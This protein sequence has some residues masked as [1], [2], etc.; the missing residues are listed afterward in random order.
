MRTTLILAIIAAASLAT[1]SPAFAWGTAAHRYIM[2]RAI[3]ML[4]ATLKPLFEPHRDELI[5]RVIDSD[6]WRTVGWEEDSNHFLD[7]GVREYGDYPFAALPREYD[8]ALETFGMATLRKNGTLPWREAEEFGNLRRAFERLGRGNGFAIGDVVLFTAVA[9]HYIQDAH[10][11]LHA[12]NN[13][14]GNLTGQEG[15]HARFETEL[16]ERFAARLSITP[17]PVSPIAN[18]RDFAFD[19]LLASYKLVEPLLAADRRAVAGKEEYDD[20]YFAKF[21]EQTRPILEQRIGASIAATAGLII[22]AWE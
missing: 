18:P 21:F 12:T 22:G 10:Q 17:P 14:D 3:E 13:H 19:V 4:P 11:P 7:F 5:L 16:L 8:A 15:L 9:S 2:R 1:A 6:L 20:D